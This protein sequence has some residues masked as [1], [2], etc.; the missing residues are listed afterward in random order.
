[1][2]EARVLYAANTGDG[3]LL[4][5]KVEPGETWKGERPVPGFMSVFI[6]P[7]LMSYTAGWKSLDEAVGA[8]ALQGRLNLLDARTTGGLH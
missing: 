4:G 3:I 2:S 1:M 7:G 6:A 5:V 8:G